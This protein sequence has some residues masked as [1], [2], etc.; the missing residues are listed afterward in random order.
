MARRV[1]RVYELVWSPTGQKIGEV[2][3]SNMRAAIRKAPSPYKKYKG[4]IYARLRN[5]D[6]GIQRGKWI[7]AHMVKFNKDGGVSILY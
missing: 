3:A 2:E 5:P 4:E 6:A 1:M 7:P